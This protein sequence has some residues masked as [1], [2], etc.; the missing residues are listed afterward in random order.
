MFN[1][2][3]DPRAGCRIGSYRIGLMISAAAAA[4]ATGCASSAPS[5]GF[6]DPGKTQIQFYSPPGA[7]VMVKGGRAQQVS[8][9]GAF[10]HRLEHSP[11]EFSV[12]NLSPGRYE[13]KYTAAEG[14][15]NVSIYGELDVHGGGS[16]TA[17]MYRRRSFVPISLPSEFYQHVDGVGD[18][19]FPYRSERYRTAI[20]QLD[21][22]RLKQG[23]VVEKVIFVADLEEAEEEL[24]ETERDIAVTER[25][26]EYAEAR[27]RLALYDFRVDVNDRMANLLR[28]DRKFIKWEEERKELDQEL[29]DLIDKHKRLK[30]LLKGDHV[31][32]RQGMLV[33][34][35][36]EVV[37]SHR[38]VVSAAEELGDVLVVM[39]VGGRHMHWGSPAE[40]PI[41]APR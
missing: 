23:D 37:Q 40:Q 34:A 24:D 13:F 12:F 39:R 32:A 17:R 10:G 38:D 26:I 22:D 27:F 7:Q 33:L 1:V 18:E 19:T 28:T 4:L 21:I 15:P 3:T 25:K 5:G 2:Y 14:L 41:V 30:A 20:D 29:D 6:S 35:T 36:E 16:E 11:E 8:S 9:Y 31:L